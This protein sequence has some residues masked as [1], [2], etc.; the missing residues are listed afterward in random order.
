MS[1]IE[2]K[3]K[4]IPLKIFV[5]VGI[6]QMMIEFLIAVF[7]T[8][9][10]DFYENEIGL[11]TGTI[12][13]AFILYAVYN[14]FNDPLVGYLA[15]K[16][17][18]YWKKYGKRYLWIVIGG[19]FWAL[20]FILLFAVP[21]V[22]PNSDALFL[23]FWLLIT[24]CIYDTFGS[25]YDVNY[26]GLIPDKFRSDKHRMKLSS[27]A[28]AF[29]II[30][31]VLGVIVP[32]M[33]IIYGDRAS[34]FRMGVVIS[35]IGI[36]LLLLLLPGIKEDQEMIDRAF[37]VD[38]QK[39]Q[40]G[41]FKLLKIALKQK[42]FIAYLCIY[43]FYQAVVVLMIGSIPY[44]VRFILK[45]DAIFEAYINL[46]YI[47][48][49]LISIPFWVKLA[50]RKGDFKKSFIIGGLLMAIFMIPLIFVDTLITI[51][52]AVAIFGIGGIGFW[53]MMLPVLSDVIDE[54]TVENG[55][56]Q[57]GFYMG[58][59]TFVSR[60]ALIIQAVTFALV[61][62]LTG[63]EPGAKTQSATALIGL[64][65]QVAVIPIILMLIGVFL[66]WRLYDLSPEKKE[67]IRAR[68]K[69]LDL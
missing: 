22:D 24:I 59:R 49:G 10:F 18:N 67:Q 58:V 2:S 15:D 6:G 5:S 42:N 48:T 30:G 32:P 27:F 19:I 34:F 60:I 17:R 65:L 68:L 7:G 39:E 69:E 40:L 44:V 31:V 23:F 4:D 63:F 57:E 21:D 52:I 43:T 9:I 47:V 66:F 36:V 26:N 51:I 38:A 64:R 41:F 8:R 37:R 20:S 12:A 13:I 16:P 55:V 33:L 61:H 62:I 35:I 54:A 50:E 29:G 28:V 53:V 3:E 11:A 45:E 14:M 56:R 1:E 25:M 46:G